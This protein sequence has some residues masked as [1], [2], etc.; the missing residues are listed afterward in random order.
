ME[1][2]RERYT[3]WLS[4]FFCFALLTLPYACSVSIS[5]IVADIYEDYT[6]TFENETLEINHTVNVHENATLTIQ[7]GANIKFSENGSLN[8]YGNLVANG[9]ETLPID[10]SS[11]IDFNRSRTLSEDFLPFH[12]LRLVDGNGYN[13][14]RLEI[15]HQGIWGT[16]CS[17]GW[18]Q[19]N[20][21]VACRELGFS[22]GTFTREFGRG[23]GQ[24]W[25]DDVRCTEADHSLRHCRHRRFGSHNCGK[26]RSNIFTVFLQV[27]NNN[28][29]I[30]L[31]ISVRMLLYFTGEAFGQLT[32]VYTLNF[33][34]I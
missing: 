4:R 29:I 28:F 20:S 6:I 19:I 25:L 9:T 34:V 15:F 11:E 8:V 17:D 32:R 23:T 16:V 14:G 3:S 30:F 7:P 21:D 27:F 24:I 2:C 13:T 33:L 22:T 12:D 10:I 31:K 1:V 18:S 5:G 26:L